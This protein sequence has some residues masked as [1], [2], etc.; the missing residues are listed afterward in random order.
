M[1]ARTSFMSCRLTPST[2]R[3]RGTPWPSVSRLRLTPPLPRSVGFGPVFFPPEGRFAHRPVQA[4]P[5]PVNA[6]QLVKPVHASLP[7]FQEY[8]SFDPLL[9]PVVGRGL[10][11]QL[12]LLQG[13]PL[14][15]RSQDV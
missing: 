8:L 5:R 6:L 9:E 12:G 1:V 13:F 7:E 2:T 3:P 10:G 11:T 14:A 15:T 4:Q